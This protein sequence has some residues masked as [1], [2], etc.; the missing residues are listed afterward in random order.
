MRTKRIDINKVKPAYYA[1]LIELN[2]QLKSSLLSELELLLIYIRASH[3]N[4]CAYCIQSHTKEAIEK[5]EKQY[6]LHALSA[7]EDSPFF[8]DEERTLL[9]VTD[10]TTNICEKGL[11]EATY[12]EAK[13]CFDDQKIA[14][15]IMAV[16]CINAWNRIGRSTLL[17]PFKS[18]N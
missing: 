6:R 8:T 15:I 14:D 11:T 18:Q 7:W 17:E 5:G 16:T 1:P 4:G 3:L 10:E 9:R 13:E 12:M 2:N